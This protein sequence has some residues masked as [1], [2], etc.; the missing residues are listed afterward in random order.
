MVEVMG[1]ILP[2]VMGM[3]M[4]TDMVTD[5]ATD[6]GKPFSADCFIDTSLKD[7]QTAWPFK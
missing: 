3:I 5:M 1:S 2:H 6:Y 7:I 4:E